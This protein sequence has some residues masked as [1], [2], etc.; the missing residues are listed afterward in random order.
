MEFMQYSEAVLP[1]KA[2]AAEVTVEV[3]IWA[4][5]WFLRVG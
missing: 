3:G 2:E 1:Q 4:Q 5:S